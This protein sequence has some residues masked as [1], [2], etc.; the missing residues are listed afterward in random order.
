[1]DFTVY[2]KIII[3][4]LENIQQVMFRNEYGKTFFK[5]RKK[6]RKIQKKE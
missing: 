5:K 3:H 2:Y 4:L 1:M 6:Q